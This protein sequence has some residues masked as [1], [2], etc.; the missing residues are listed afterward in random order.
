MRK[1]FITLFAVFV[2]FFGCQSIM[3]VDNDYKNS[4]L[5]IQIDEIDQS[6][7]NIEL[8]TQKIYTE[9]VKIIK[10]SDTIYYFLL[11]ETSHSITSVPVVGAIKNV[12]VKSYPYAGQDMNNGYTKV[13]IVTSRPVNLTTSLRT[14]DPSIS[15]KLDPSRLARLDNVFERYSQRLAQNNIQSPLNEFRKTASASTPVM[16]S[17]VNVPSGEKIAS[18]QNSQAKSLE[19]YQN[20]VNKQQT[21]QK[22]QTQVKK[23]N[24]KLV[25]SQTA[26]VK[27]VSSQKQ[28][29]KAPVKPQPKATPASKPVQVAS[30]PAT[31]PVQTAKP[32]TKPVQVASKPV[33]TS[34]HA[35]KPVQ[36]ASKPATKPVQAAPKQAVS[37]NMPEKIAK[38]E[39]KPIQASKPVQVASKPA[40]KPVSADVPA[41]IEPSV[42]PIKETKEPLKVNK[43]LEKIKE[44]EKQ[45]VNSKPIDVEF[46]QSDDKAK[47]VDETATAQDEQPQPVSVEQTPNVPEAPIAPAQNNNQALLMLISASAVLLLLLANIIRKKNLAKANVEATHAQNPE[48][49]QNMLQRAIIKPHKPENQAY[50]ADVQPQQADVQPQQAMEQEVSIPSPVQNIQEYQNNEIVQNQPV[51]NEVVEKE[52]L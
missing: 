33:Q 49:V 28:T 45:I 27:N 50:V 37:S 26:P 5:K 15:P 19:D 12:F 46:S 21:A 22:Q 6:D 11:P 29:A 9:P 7:Y 35:T 34:K 36:V 48:D 23:T 20:K 44:I 24:P 30:K 1:I 38:A 43:N 52:P 18:S 17:N 3:A 39:T 14:L 40:A 25:T 41:D 2:L 31:K 51:Y 8:Y 47:V 16:K 42:Q 4:L 10:K 13:A 32:V